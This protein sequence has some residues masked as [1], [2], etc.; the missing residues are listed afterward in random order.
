MPTIPVVYDATNSA[1]NKRVISYSITSY[2]RNE[3]QLKQKLS[4]SAIT[5]DELPSFTDWQY[6]RSPSTGYYV[7]KK[8]STTANNKQLTLSSSVTLQPYELQWPPVLTDFTIPPQDG[9]D[10]MPYSG[11]KGR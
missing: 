3:R 9:F 8:L 11:L 4:A 10:K 6:I 5:K 1:N 2:H 7:P